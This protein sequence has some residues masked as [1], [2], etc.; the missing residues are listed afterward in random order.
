MAAAPG[1]WRE[2]DG[3]PVLWP[4]AKTA[5][6]SVAHPLLT[7]IAGEYGAWVTYKDLAERIQQTTG[8]RTRSLLQNWIGEVLGE[9]AR[10]CV[11]NGEPS[12]TSLVVHADQT[13]G[14]G[15]VY[16][17]EEFGRGVPDDLERA[18]A[19][20]RFA[21]YR[22]FGAEIPPDG[23][24]MLTPLVRKGRRRLSSTLSPPAT[25]PT[26][27]LQLPRTGVCDRCG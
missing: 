7:Q 18:A 5:W 1:T 27:H 21:C 20:D 16:A 8:I 23:R 10:Q 11:E 4:E 9:V 3:S 13:I 24:P 2:I 15:Y 12:L 6:A 19:E 26:C 14:E 25:C 17:L 22:H